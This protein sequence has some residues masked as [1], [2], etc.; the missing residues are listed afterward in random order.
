M[1]TLL[2]IKEFIEVYAAEVSKY[3]HINRLIYIVTIVILII[4]YVFKTIKH[5]VR[6]YLLNR[7]FEYALKNRSLLNE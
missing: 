4:L 2:P 3:L 7:Y 1:N 5:R 6:I